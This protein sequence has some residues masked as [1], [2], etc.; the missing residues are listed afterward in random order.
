MAT[1]NVQCKNSVIIIIIIL[2]ICLQLGTVQIDRL[3][4]L[5]PAL[6]FKVQENQYNV[7]FWGSTS[8]YLHLTNV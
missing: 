8:S 4:A 6:A 3:A 1:I 5:N 2:L 7:S